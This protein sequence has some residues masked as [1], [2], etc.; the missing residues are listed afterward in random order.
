[1]ALSK[2]DNPPQ[3][4]II[5][6][7]GVWR[8]H[9]WPFRFLSACLRVAISARTADLV[10]IH[11]ASRGSALR[12]LIVASI[13]HLFGLPVVLHIHGAE[14]HDFANSLPSV[15]R[16]LLVSSLR[17]CARIVVLG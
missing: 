4:E 8:S 12:K 10:H 16:R 1:G 5:D 7:C 6:T 15:L 9:L 13:A 14:F 2:L 3:C 11:M 17:K